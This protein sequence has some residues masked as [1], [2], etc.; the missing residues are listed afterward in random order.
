MSPSRRP[1]GRDDSPARLVETSY[2]PPRPWHRTGTRALVS[3]Q[4]QWVLGAVM[5]VLL[6]CKV[7][8][9]SRYTKE[10]AAQT[11]AANRRLTQVGFLD[12]QQVQGELPAGDSS[13]PGIESVS[14]DA[15]LVTGGRH[16]VDVR[17][18]AA[19]T[20]AAGIL[21]GSPS[22]SFHLRYALDS[23]TASARVS[24]S[25]KVLGLQRVL[26]VPLSIAA[27]DED[28]TVGPMMPLVVRLQDPELLG[29]GGFA[30]AFMTVFDDPGLQ[31]S[32][33]AIGARG[34]DRLVASGGVDERGNGTVT[35]WGGTDARERRRYPGHTGAVYALSFDASATR[36]ASGGADHVLRIHD[37]DTGALL[38]TRGEHLDDLR[39]ID[40]G[41]SGERLLTGGWDGRLFERDG[42]GA[43][44]AEIDV[45]VAINAVT[46]D[47]SRAIAAGGRTFEAGAVVFV[48]LDS[49]T[50]E[51]RLDY[52]EPSTALAVLGDRLAIAEGRGT[53]RI[54]D[55]PTR[56]ELAVLNPP[57]APGTE[58]CVEQ[59]RALGI[60]GLPAS[61]DAVV[62]LVL[63]PRDESRL[64]AATTDGAVAAWDLGEERMTNGTTFAPG[65]LAIQAEGA[66]ARVAMGL[67]NGTT[68][69]IRFGER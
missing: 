29:D 45:G 15:V 3:R 53:I 7:D 52:N 54:I 56:A 59:A 36:L 67:G 13:G 24:V 50:I 17:I 38:S 49:K 25:P 2:R 26:T 37:V 51:A 69:V 47:G 6:G 9:N 48:D 61:R 66:V 58:A 21:V 60:D 4:R 27:V 65:L 14:V 44:R 68:Q 12:A 42:D 28:G 31:V 5:L 41:A 19:G 63:D 46:V 11:N 8:D 55:L 10:S 39:A 16:D 1:T 23:G 62:A 34:S 22:A 64:V 43:P 30:G 35:V 18:R 33:V 40:Y 32:A 20:D 57:C